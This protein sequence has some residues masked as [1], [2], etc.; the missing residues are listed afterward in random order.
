MNKSL[1]P[2]NASKL[3]QDLEQNC[4]QISKL[5]I[6]NSD[7]F[8]VEKLE[9]DI[10]P[11][12]AWSLSVDNWDDDWSTDTKRQ[13]IKNSIFLHQIK[14]TKKAITQALEMVGVLAEIIEWWEVN[15]KMT[16]HSFNIIA[17]INDNIKR[18]AKVIINHDTQQKLI[19]LIN[20]VKPARSHFNFKLGVKFQ[21]HL[22]HKAIFKNKQFHN[23]YLTSKLSNF[24]V[25]SVISTTIRTSLHKQITFYV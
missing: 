2:I 6:K 3:L 7:V 16:P 8:N 11:W 4:A 5:P 23:F 24:E 13:I 12:L 19:N 14:G 18:N 21:S 1:L 9:A 20:N 17:I 15:P 10:L 22:A 25:K